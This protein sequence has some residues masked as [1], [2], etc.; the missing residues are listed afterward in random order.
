MVIFVV[1]TAPWPGLA[2][3][4][5]P[6]Y[7]AGG[8]ILFARFGS[9]GNVELRP[10]TEGDPERNTEFVLTNW[11]TDA[12]FVFTGSSSKGYMPTAFVLALIVATPAPWRRRWRAV[13][14]GLA[15][16]TVYAALRMA[17]FLVAA[18]SEDN[19][20][21]VFTLGPL[22]KSALDYLFWIV[23]DSFAGWLI[24]PLPIWAL[25]CFRRKDWQAV[26]NR[27]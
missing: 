7:R 8:N 1:L 13:L 15:C 3:A 17:V 14:W 27:A 20:L 2:D 26:L 22:A 10:S 5:A 19:G 24:L 21:A 25:L 6:L 16:V 4:Y 11:R 12:R 9:S 23:V 18:F